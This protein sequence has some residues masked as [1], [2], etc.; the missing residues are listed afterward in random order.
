MARRG[1]NKVILIGNL[2]SNPESRATGGGESVT[3]IRVATSENWRDAGGTTQERTEWHA[4]VFFGKL[5]EIAAQYLAKGAK[6]YVE[7]SLRTRKWQDKTGQDRYVTE[8][9]GHHMQMLSRSNQYQGQDNPQYAP[10]AGAAVEDDD[11]DIPF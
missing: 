4:V 5:A 3:N 8:I 7:G 6:V 10:H 1:V 2:G 11:D 9:V